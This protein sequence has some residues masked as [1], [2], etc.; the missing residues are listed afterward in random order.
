MIS[1]FY[2]NRQTTETETRYHSF[3][4]KTLATVYA[5]R[6]FCI[7]LQNIHFVIVSDCSAVTQTLEK[8]GINAHIAR[9]SLEL[10]NF[11]FKIIHKPGSK[12][13]HI[14]ALSQLSGVL[15]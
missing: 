5:L 1:V 10:Q 7:Y 9:W 15:I 12:M 6:R 14:D 3:E 11:D 2:F 4:L 13:T 8:Q